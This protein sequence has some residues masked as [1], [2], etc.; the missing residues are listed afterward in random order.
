MG[1]ARHDSRVRDGRK[2]G[3]E[4]SEPLTEDMKT[5]LIARLII[6]CGTYKKALEEIFYSSSPDDFEYQI[7]LHALNKAREFLKR[8]GVKEQP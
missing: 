4:M 8:N 6:E 3:D 2:D 7:A 1:H 5:R